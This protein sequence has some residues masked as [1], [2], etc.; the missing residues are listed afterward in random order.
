VV[1]GLVDL[2]AGLEVA[3]AFL[4][5]VQEGVAVAARVGR[6]AVHKELPHYGARNA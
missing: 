2:V 3:R 4:L 1:A 5:A 6:G